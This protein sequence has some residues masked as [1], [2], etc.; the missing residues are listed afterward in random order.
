MRA[1]DIIKRKRDGKGLTHKEIAFLVRGVLMGDIPDYQL[2]AFLMAVYFQGMTMDETLAMTRE[3]RNSGK[4]LD[5]SH[6]PGKKVDKHSTGGVGDKLTLTIAPLVAAGGVSIP[7]LSGRGLG[8]TGGTI[9][10]LEAI[11]GFRTQLGLNEFIT[12]VRDIGLAIMGQTKELAPADDRLYALRDVTATIDSIPLIAS[13]IMS[14]KL[15]EGIDGLVLDV[16]VGSGAFMKDIGRARELAKTMVDI[17]K[18]MDK[19]VVALLTDMDQP[20]GR[21]VGNS[22]EIN[23][24]IDV[25]NGEGPEDVVELT[26]ELGAWMLKLGG[27]V[28]DLDDGK[29]MLKAFIANGQGLERFRDLIRHQGGD[30]RVVEDPTILPMARGRM[31]VAAKEDGFIARIDTEGVGMSAMLLGAGRTKVGESIDPSVGIVL[32][33]KLGDMVVKGEPLATVYYNDKE[34]LGVVLERLGSA[35]LYSKLPGER[36]ALV[37][38][39]VR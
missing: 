24:A 23:E 38:G 11:P 26:L 10:K 3:M 31:D 21:A 19:E 2:S 39:V 35:F 4:V 32:Q 12:Q 20:L 7:M 18:G 22:L 14:K 33:K 13:S 17:G 8:H 30:P 9:D 34:R 16:K 25:L 1:Y 5:L 29:G 6:I 27:K 36:P 37:H 15:A 28:R